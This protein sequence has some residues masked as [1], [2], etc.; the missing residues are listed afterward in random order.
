VRPIVA[1]RLRC[2]GILLY[3]AALTAF[4]F[5]PAF[6]AMVIGKFLVAFGDMWRDESQAAEDRLD[7]A[8][9]RLAKL[10]EQR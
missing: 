5:V 3:C 2:I 9:T 1:A 8:Q 4:G 6:V 10:K 7:A